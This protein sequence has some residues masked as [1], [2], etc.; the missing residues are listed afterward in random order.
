MSH[1]KEGGEQG[2]SLVQEFNES[3]LSSLGIP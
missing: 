1:E 2:G 3:T